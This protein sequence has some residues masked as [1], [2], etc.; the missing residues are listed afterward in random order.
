MI[1]RIVNSI[2]LLFVLFGFAACKRTSA[3]TPPATATP[4]P[5]NLRFVGYDKD[6]KKTKP[7]DMSFQI[8]LPGR[9]Q[10]TEFL[11]LGDMVPNTRFRLT[12]FQYKTRFNPQTRK[13]EDASELTLVNVETNQVVVLTLSQLIDSPPVF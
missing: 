1:T 6:A 12:A 5:P 3:V 9:R 7:K 11:K 2:L 10:P 8:D 4:P 13:E